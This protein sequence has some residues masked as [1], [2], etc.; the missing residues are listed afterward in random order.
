MRQLKIS[1]QITYR[2]SISL[3]LYLKEIKK[4]AGI[5]I[6][7]EVE[8]SQRIKEGDMQALKRLA[9]A[10]LLFVVSVAKQY[11]NRGL[12]LLD[13]ISEGN[14]GIVK[15]AGKFD[16]T[17]GF[18]FI[19][20]AVWWIRQAILQAIGE[21]SRMVRIPLN[22]VG[23]INKIIKAIEKLKQELGRYPTNVEIAELTE[24]SLKEINECTSIGGRH[25]SM[26][27]PLIEG[28][29]VTLYDI[30][31]SEETPSPDTKLMLDSLKHEIQRALNTLPSREANVVSSYYGLVNGNV[32]TLEE[33]G[34]KMGITRERVR[35][36][37]EKAV[38]KLKHTSRSKVLKSYL[39]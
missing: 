7:E 28:E 24:Y 8:L 19:S 2:D 21:Q 29:D 17:K 14:E 37:R 9:E 13:L 11:Q 27:A 31:G 39:G 5:T 3:D 34:E 38:R 6:E 12:P 26:D 15:A 30:I 35:Q 22:K 20:Y 33:I 18:K 25:T 4:K 16:A 36:I 23:M 1:K 32:L 10:N